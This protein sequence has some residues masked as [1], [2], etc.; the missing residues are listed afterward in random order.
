LVDAGSRS[1]E[2]AGGELLGCRIVK[3]VEGDH[4]GDPPARFGQPGAHLTQ[5]GASQADERHGHAVD[6][7]GE[8][9]E[10]IEQLGLGPLD[11][12]DHDHEGLVGC[13]RLGEPADRPEGL[14]DRTRRR[15]TVDTGEHVGEPLM[16]G[17]RREQRSDAVSHHLGR[18][19]VVERSNLA[20][21]LGDRREGGCAGAVAADLD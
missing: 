17:A 10:Q 9:F 1:T 11:V 20:Q 18:R 3:A 7:L 12:V 19:L 14:L 21:Q 8:V 6:P 15:R 4:V 5:L 13:Q 2:Q 16:I